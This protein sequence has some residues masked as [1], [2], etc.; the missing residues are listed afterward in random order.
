MALASLVADYSDSDLS[1]GGEYDEESNDSSS[2]KTQE[3][4]IKQEPSD[5]VSN[6]FGTSDQTDDDEEDEKKFSE[7]TTCETPVKSEPEE[8]LPNPLSSG[9]EKLPSIFEV[10]KSRIGTS[11]FVNPFEEAEQAKNQILEKHVKLTQA[12]P[13]KPAHQPVC[14][15]FRK[16]K[17]HM[18]KNCRFFHDPENRT[19]EE[20]VQTEKSASVQTSHQVYHPSA[21]FDARRRPLEPEPVDEDNYM[22]G[23]NKKKRFG[24]AEH[25]VPPR[26]AFESLQKQREMERPWTL[27][28]Q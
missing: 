9:H 3:V 5:S 15:K 17:C 11:V 13:K 4:R 18:G 25:L 16:G 19:V 20:N 12:A 8:K 22:A 10:A 2:D 14:W 28:Q 24:V 21:Y 6:F 1:D 27:P 26:K 7:S 23:R